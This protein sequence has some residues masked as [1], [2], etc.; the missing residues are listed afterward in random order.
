MGFS[1][2]QVINNRI[3]FFFRGGGGYKQIFIL[4]GKD[5]CILSTVGV[6]NLLDI[7]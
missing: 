5:I 7:Q 2:F 1:F 6:M 3:F 4:L